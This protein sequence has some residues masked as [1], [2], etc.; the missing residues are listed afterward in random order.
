[1]LIGIAGKNNSGKD[2][3]AMRLKTLI[4][5]QID[6]D[7]SVV[8]FAGK[9]KEAL[10]VLTG[11]EVELFENRE[12]KE[13]FS[14]S[15]FC[16]KFVDGKFSYCDRAH[17]DCECFTIRDLLIYI[18]TDLFRN[19]I[20]EDIW[21]ELLLKDY[22][23]EKNWIVSDVRFLNEVRRIKSLGGCVL[24]LDND[25]SQGKNIGDELKD[26]ADFVFYNEK[27]NDESLFVNLKKFLYI[28]NKN[29]PL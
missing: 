7:V 9:L 17:E 22:T 21:V 2:Y 27:R 20:H 25:N 11:Y 14:P 8:K 3:V 6:E 19:Q 16:R 4:E 23:E 24:Y 26:V 1:M 13:T 5:E 15:S 28:C 18:G 12:F 29:K 10:S